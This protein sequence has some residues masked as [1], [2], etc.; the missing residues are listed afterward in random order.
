MEGGFHSWLHQFKLLNECAFHDLKLNNICSACQ[1]PIPFLLSSKRLGYA[2][3]CKCG[4]SLAIFSVSD[5]DEWKGP[6][7][8]NQT[9]LRWIKSNVN[10]ENMQ[11]KWIVHEQHCDLK[12]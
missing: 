10:Q 9:V 3:R 2:F 11:S 7:Q 1:E 12:L 5:W 8:L 4:H 6:D